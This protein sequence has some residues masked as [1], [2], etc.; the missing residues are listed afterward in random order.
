[1]HIET[2]RSGNSRCHLL[3]QSYWQDGKPKKRTLCNLSALPEHAIEALK[4]ALKR[5]PALNPDSADVEL[6]ASRAHGAVSASLGT[7]RDIGLDRVIF[8]RPDRRRALVIAMIVARLIRPGAKL[9]VERELGAAGTTTLAALLGVEGVSV[10]E[11]YAAMDWLGARQGAIERKLARRHLGED[12]LVLYDVSSSYMEGNACPMAKR[13]YSRDRRGDRPQ[14]VYGLLCTRDGCPVSI[15]AFA[16]NTGDPMTLASQ[17]RKVRDSFGIRRVVL[18]GDRGMIA[19]TRIDR[20]L[21]PNGIDWITALRASSIRKLVD[22]GHV[23]PGLFDTWGLARVTTPD[24]PG[25]R[26]I[27]CYNPVLA[28]ERKRNR[29]GL[30]D[31][32]ET[33]A[34]DFAARHAAGDIDRDE[35]NRRLGTLRRRK[36][37]KH[38]RFEFDEG[39]GTFSCERDQASIDAEAALDGLYVIRTNVDEDEIEDVEAVRVYKSLSRVERAFRSLKTVSLRIRP[40]FHW[41]DD[42]VRAH[43]LICMLAWYVEW[44]MRRRL[45]P[46]LF[47][48]EDGAPLSANPV[49]PPE[50]SEKARRKD[51]RR[52]TDDGLAVCDFRDLLG[53]LGTLAATEIA[54]GTDFAVPAL[55]KPTELQERAFALLGLRPHP[56][57]ALTEKGMTTAKPVQ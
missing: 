2:T 54:T 23:T 57:P 30:L 46:L 39:S 31:A 47:A 28:A 1:M 22:R 12:D 45:A 38:F 34:R 14:I 11:L 49:A 32:T 4:R 43:L 5:G 10:D 13:G 33:D 9:R 25:E 44:H 7:L 16:G 17:V 35:L 42:R 37:A 40:I 21:A 55:T 29:D 26:L 36:M 41:R 18:V 15:E 19:Q 8:H 52:K 27:V 6:R 53:H 3:R 51:K 48:E 50:R 56:A 20:D 24:Y